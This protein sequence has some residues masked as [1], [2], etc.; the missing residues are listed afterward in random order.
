MTSAVRTP[1]MVLQ[2]DHPGC[3]AIP[4]V[5]PRIFVP[6][7]SLWM[8]KH[9]YLTLSFPHLHYCDAHWETDVK[10]DRLLDDRVKARFEALAKKLWP[11]DVK[12][13]FDA[14]LIEPLNVFSPEYG[15][16]MKRLGF[17]LDGLGYSLG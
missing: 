9:K 16:Y 13:N 4:V 10:L 12:P 5:A 17:K 14:A 8:P 3:L 1:D 6:A 7:Q 2:C 11:H 15:H